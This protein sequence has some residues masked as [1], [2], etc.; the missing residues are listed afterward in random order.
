MDSEYFRYIFP[1]SL[2]VDDTNVVAELTWYVLSFAV[3]GTTCVIG[4]WLG[5]GSRPRFLYR[6]LI[7]LLILLP[8][9]YFDRPYLTP[10]LTQLAGIAIG[11][12]LLI[13]ARWHWRT[14]LISPD[15]TPSSP[16]NPAL[17]FSLANLLGVMLVAAFICA[18]IGKELADDWNWQLLA[19]QAFFIAELTV[20]PSSGV[21]CVLSSSPVWVRLA[22]LVGAFLVLAV[23]WWVA[24]ADLGYTLI[25]ISWFA[26]IVLVLICWVWLLKASGWARRLLT[27][28]HNSSDTPGDTRQT[29]TVMLPRAALIAFSLSLLLPTVW[30]YFR[31]L[32]GLPLESVTTANRDACRQLVA[33]AKSL[34]DTHI[35][36]KV[37]TDQE[38]H[39]YINSCQT[40]LQLTR[41]LVRHAAEPELNEFEDDQRLFG[42]Q[43]ETLANALIA[44]QMQASK[45]SDWAALLR[46]VIDLLWLS[47]LQ[48]RGRDYAS[49]NAAHFNE[50]EAIRHLTA[51]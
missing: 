9:L 50:Q 45:D 3:W 31:V 28:R 39:E 38:L 2:F 1:V 41:R 22:A 33:A 12:R 42:Y 13:G 11:A 8:L 23:F 40:A 36:L 24:Y 47:N 14:S 46:S 26:W 34:E 15:S 37:A 51:R 27:L 35:D 43:L 48:C 10:L 19:F 30:I 6:C 25:L 32:V 21:W 29:S 49:Y 16:R 18:A 20:I 17:Q 44:E 5:V 7:V 4:L